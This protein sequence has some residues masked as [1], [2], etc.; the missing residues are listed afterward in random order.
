[1]GAPAPPPLGRRAVWRAICLALATSGCV[2]PIGPEFQDPPATQ[3]YAPVI[4]A[5]EPPLGKRVTVPSF[6]VTVQDPNV[7]DDLF[8][9][10][11]A[12]FP[13]VGDNMKFLKDVKVDHHPDGTL[14]SEDVRL[15]VLCNAVVPLPSHQ[16]TVI[17]ADRK[18]S[19]NDRSPSQPADP[20]RLPDE[21]RKIVGTWTLDLECPP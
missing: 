4:L 15:D 6:R 14:L 12:D 17:V 1:M 10:F 16:I 19:L 2:L 21:A 3:N 7:G 11:V 20:L 5:A 8:V 13:P 9:R 18:F